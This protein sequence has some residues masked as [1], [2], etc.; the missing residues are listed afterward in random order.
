MPDIFDV[1]MRMIQS[2]PDIMQN[3]NAR[4][5]I[6]VIQSRDANRGTQIAQNLCQSMGMTPEQALQQAKSYFKIP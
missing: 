6:E 2:R 3:P 4:S 5:M 1:A